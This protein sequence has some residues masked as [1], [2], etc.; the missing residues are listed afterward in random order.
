M[1]RPWLPPCGCNEGNDRS[2][3]QLVLYNSLVDRKVPFV[4]AAGPDSKQISWYTCGERQRQAVAAAAAA[5]CSCCLCRTA[6][7]TDADTDADAAVGAGGALHGK[8]AQVLQRSALL[9]AS[10]PGCFQTSPPF[11]RPYC[12]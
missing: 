8:G 6:A 10:Q 1:Q 2:G 5:A 11:R 12:V 4:P 3:P 7:A 9:A